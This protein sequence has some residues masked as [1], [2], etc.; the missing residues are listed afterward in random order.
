MYTLSLLYPMLLGYPFSSYGETAVILLQ[1]A[2]VVALI[3]AFAEKPPGALAMLGALGAYGGA[4]YA[5]YATATAL[6]MPVVALAG[7]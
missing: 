3:I 2:V 6:V 4:C 1:Q 7:S 5:L